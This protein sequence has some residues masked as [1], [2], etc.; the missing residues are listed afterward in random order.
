MQIRINTKNKG[1]L[2]DSVTEVSVPL[3]EFEIVYPALCDSLSWTV[4]MTIKDISVCLRPQRTSDFLFITRHVQIHS[5]T[6][7]LTCF[8][9]TAQTMQRSIQSE[10]EKQTNRYTPTSTI[11]RVPLCLSDS[12]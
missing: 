6:Y 9:V 7:L 2:R 11:V 12:N 3:D 10:T 1:R 4:Q 5:F 8:I